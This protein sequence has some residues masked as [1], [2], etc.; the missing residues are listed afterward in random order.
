MDKGRIKEG[1]KQQI[2]IADMSKRNSREKLERSQ[3]SSI[4]TKKVYVVENVLF[5]IYD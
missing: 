3:P 2:L 5:N 1:Q 4:L